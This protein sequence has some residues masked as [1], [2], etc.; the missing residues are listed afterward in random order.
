MQ[1]ATASYRTIDHGKGFY[2]V[3]FQDFK[4]ETLDAWLQAADERYPMLRAL[5]RLRILYDVRPVI[6]FT[7]YAI[8][9]FRQTIYREYPPD[10]RAAFVVQGNVLNLLLQMYIKRYQ[11]NKGKGN[12]RVFFSYD[13]A[14]RWLLE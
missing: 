3:V 11:A 13:A 8:H 7:P 4:R 9:C 2:E 14:M 12:G 1:T 6:T 10:T 5:P